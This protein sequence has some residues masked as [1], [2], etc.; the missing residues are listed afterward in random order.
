M[1][2]RL[3][4]GAKIVTIALLITKFLG[5]VYLIP[6]YSLLDSSKIKIFGNVYSIFVVFIQFSTLGF[7]IGV[8]MLISR[9]RNEGNYR[10]A[11][12]TLR[13]ALPVVSI[14]GLIS[15]LLMFTLAPYLADFAKYTT[16]KDIYV[17]TLRILSFA[18]LIIPVLAISRG[19][20][21]GHEDML[22][23][24]ISMVVE[25]VVRVVLLISGIFLFTKVVTN[26]QNYA[27][28][29]TVVAAVV[30]AV[31]ALV[32]LV[33]PFKKY[34]K[35]NRSKS[36]YVHDYSFQYVVKNIMFLSVPFIIL[37]VATSIFDLID[38]NTIARVLPGF[39]LDKRTID[40]IQETYTVRIQKLGVIILTLSNGV[41]ASVVPSITALYVKQDFKT[42]KVRITQ[43]ALLAL[44]LTS[45][46][47]L[48]SA[49][50]AYEVVYIISGYSEIAS[51]IF[52][53]AAFGFILLGNTGTFISCIIT[54]KHSVKA[55]LILLAGLAAK[56]ISIPIITELYK[57][58]SI[59]PQYI[60]TTTSII[61]FTTSFILAFV[62][63]I[64]CNFINLRKYFRIAFKIVLS[65]IITAAFLLIVKY[66]L[67]SVTEST[68]GVTNK[69]MYIGMMMILGLTS[70]LLYLKTAEIMGYSKYIGA[71]DTNYILRKLKI[72]K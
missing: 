46:A 41:R 55:T 31:A 30:A 51:Q 40:V 15:F 56:I 39:D 43:V 68:S 16:D 6:M 66:F 34:V 1:S 52:R 53:V 49:I 13:Y 59:N 62:V 60:F 7:P 4:K 64:K 54:T 61:G 23:S 69:F 67:P 18:L 17:T 33:K 57:Y 35:Y 24:S 5:V 12:K 9:F 32:V 20:I 48:F 63:I 21:Q 26:N 27:L 70:L 50:F 38:A 37:A 65:L 47:S 19:Y 42:I 44:F 22:P 58:F 2:N 71:F 72:K 11:N 28:Y 14:L 10:M 3:I 8:S 36:V 29:S 45:F 25:Q